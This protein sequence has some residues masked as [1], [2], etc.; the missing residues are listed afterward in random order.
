MRKI[1]LLLASC[2]LQFVH[3]QSLVPTYD[4][5]TNKY[6]Y[7]EKDKI[8]WSL[9]PIYKSARSFEGNLAIVSD[10]EF[11]FVIDL[12]GKKVSPDFKSV[13]SVSNQ[14]LLPYICQE[15]GGG[16][17]IYDTQF[18][19]LCATS[20]ESISYSSE[21]NVLSIRSGNLY[22]LMDWEGNVLIPPTY[23]NV[24]LENYYYACGYKRC[25]KDGINREMFD[26]ALVRVQ[27]ENGKYGIVTLDNVL[28]VPLTYG[29]SYKLYKGTK[30][31]YQNA[32]K[33]YLLSSKKQELGA[34]LQEATMRILARNRELAAIYPTD[35]PAVEKTIVQKVKNGYAFFKG[36]KQVGKTYQS[37]DRYDKC[38]VVSINGMYGIADLLGTEIVACENENISV[39]NIDMGND[40]FL[41]ENKGKYRLLNADGTG[42]S[43][44][45]YE[46]I[47]FPSN[48][49]GVAIKNGLYWLIDS[50]G[51]LAS[52]RGY[53]N[54]DNYS[55]KGKIYAELLGYRTELT[56]SGKE[57]SPIAKQVF[58]EAYQIPLADRAQEKYDKYMLCISLDEGNREGYCS[59]SWNNIG[60]MFEDLGDVDKAM[61]Y[62]ERARN[63]GNET[64]RKN[65]KRIKLDR[66]L[67]ALQQVGTS[68]AQLSQTINTSNTNM[69]LQQS[70]GYYGNSYSGTTVE[71]ATTA[72]SSS[73]RSYE[74]WKQQYDRWERN[75]KGC[76]DALTNTGHKTKKNGQDSGGSADGSWGVVTF[77]G[78]KMNLRKAQKEMRET[79]A[80]ARKDGHNIPQSNYETVTVSF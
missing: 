68:L 5:V 65:I 39:W 12:H 44:E 73:K 28:I 77:S 23:K 27:N 30:R 55:Q 7:K 8:D 76:Y 61:G 70:T 54:I 29:D 22:G 75:A 2:I 21:S 48:G 72:G 40:V 33:P 57:M 36:E 56:I 63:M 80:Q 34:S 18:Q 25:D 74:F 4:K 10:G 17:K 35:L 1:A 71:T 38:C 79:R 16:Y 42:A 67:S 15:V 45:N 41:V 14:E 37:I 78:M 49:A 43:S 3:G 64:A 6:G 50:K 47:F 69:T 32:I 19:P 20:Y 59:V 26:G 53:E 62:Y 51:K 24:S 52:L 46:M 58:D 9:P 66:T 60:A 31:H 13:K 11:E